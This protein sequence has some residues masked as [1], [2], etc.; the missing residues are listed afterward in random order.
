MQ[1]G[2]LLLIKSTVAIM[3]VQGAECFAVLLGWVNKVHRRGWGNAW[4][5]VTLSR[6]GWRSWH[7]VPHHDKLSA[8]RWVW[9]I[10]SST[11]SPFW[12]VSQLEWERGAMGCK[13]QTAEAV[14]TGRLKCSTEDVA[15]LAGLRGS[16]RASSE[17]DVEDSFGQKD[18]FYPQAGLQPKRKCTLCP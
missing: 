14:M 18:S 3:T 16:S 12:E 10:I 8:R 5:A 7:W 6:N 9:P 13:W 4:V 17:L 15:V 1:Y 2:T 11:S